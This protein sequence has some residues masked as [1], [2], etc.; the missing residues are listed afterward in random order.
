MRYAIF[1][2]LFV[3]LFDGIGL[4][5]N[6]CHIMSMFM[7]FM[8]QRGEE[9][10]RKRELGGQEWESILVSSGFSTLLCTLDMELMRGWA[11]SCERAMN[12]VDIM[13]RKGLLDTLGIYR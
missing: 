10:E 8:S 6:V 3:V 13:G 12:D 9:R 11:F 5:C 2:D 7:L 1:L 4:F